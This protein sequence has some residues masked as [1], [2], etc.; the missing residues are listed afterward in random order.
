MSRGREQHQ[1]RARRARAPATTHG[2]RRPN[3][4]VVRSDSAPNSGFA[5]TETADPTPVTTPKTSSLWP[6]ETTC[7]C[8]AS[9]TWIGPKKPAHSPSPASVTAVTHRRVTGSTGSASADTGRRW[10]IRYCKVRRKNIWFTL[11]W[12]TLRKFI[13]IRHCLTKMESKN[14]L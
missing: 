10:V 4:D 2:T 3:R 11:D 7:A 14:L 9:S 1:R 5:T 12:S 6:G 13:I 8:W